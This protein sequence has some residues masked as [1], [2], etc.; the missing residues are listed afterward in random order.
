LTLKTTGGGPDPDPTDPPT[1]PPG[2]TWQAGTVYSAGDQVT[3][4]GA[5]YRCLQGHQ[6]QPGWEP[7]NTPAL[8]Q[9]V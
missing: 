2:G 8:W 6:A 4:G 5:T 3:Y 1:D 7:P 9:R